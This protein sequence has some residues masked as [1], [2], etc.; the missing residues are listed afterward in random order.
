MKSVTI[1]EIESLDPET[2]T[3]VDIRNREDYNRSTVPHA[4]NIPIEHFQ[5]GLPELDRAKP[6]YVLCHTGEKSEAIVER[7]GEAGYD[8][9]NITGGYRAILRMQLSRMVKN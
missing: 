8:S 3:I 1:Q 4:V 5:D 6:V 7:L 9:A 2:V